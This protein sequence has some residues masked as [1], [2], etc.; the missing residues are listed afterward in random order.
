MTSK[1]KTGGRF[2]SVIMIA[3][4]MAGAGMAT[5]KQ[6]SAYTHSTTGYWPGAVTGYQMLGSHYDW[7]AHLGG[8]CWKPMVYGSG[9]LVYRSPATTGTQLIAVSYQLQRYNSS[10]LR[11]ENFGQQTHQS[12]L[13]AGRSSIQM[14]RVEF[15]PHTGSG[16]FKVLIAV[17]WGNSDGTQTFGTR[18][19]DYNQWGDYACNTRFKCSAGTGWVWLR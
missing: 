12:Y 17:G 11:W 6:A 8:G 19:L 14:P 15:L 5:P 10:T 4:I 7:C 9:P 18:H 3:I 2:F 16:Y 13:Y 1:L